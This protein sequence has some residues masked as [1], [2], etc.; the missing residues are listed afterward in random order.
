MLRTQGLDVA[1]VHAA[2]LRTDDVDQCAA[3]VL[4]PGVA[5][6]SLLAA[7]AE[8][9]RRGA[10]LV[11]FGGNGKAGL[12]RFLGTPADALLPVV[13]PP[14]PVPPPEPPAPPPPEKKPDPKQP[15]PALEEGEKEAYRVALLLVIDT[16][17][18]MGEK[19]KLQMAKQSAIAAAGA[20]SPQDRVGVIA[21][22]DDAR[23]VAA[24]QDATDLPTLN[25]KISALRLGNRTNFAAPLKMGYPRILAQPCGIR[26]VI[27]MTDGCETIPGVIEPMIRDGAAKGVTLST[28]GIGDDDD[29]DGNRL[30]K[31]VEWGKGKMYRARDPSRLPE[32]VTLDT[33]RFTVSKRDEAKKKDRPKTDA[34]DL[35]TPPADAPPVPADKPAPPEPPRET[36]APPRRPHVAS[37]ATCI[38]GLEK[39]EWPAL[40]FAETTPARPASQVVLAW[41]DATP[42]LTLG[43]AGLGRVA[44]ISAG[45]ASPEAGE[46]LRW[47]AAPQFLAQ[48]VRSVVDPPP[49]GAAPVAAEFV[50]TD[51]G[52][53]FVRVAAPGGGEL[54]LDP[55]RAGGPIAARCADRGTF[56]ITE[57]GAMPSAG[58]F[59]GTFSAPGAPPRRVVAVSAGPRPK[60]AGT[61]TRVATASGADVVDAAPPSHEGAPVEHQEPRELELVAAAAGLLLV[62]TALR[63]LARSA[64]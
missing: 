22:D 62:E 36:A 30:S 5:G 54:S 19:N 35:P 6:D 64:A 32:I 9:V 21:F 49:P 29:I 46:F 31:M 18:S 34:E 1:D 14:V 28:I 33:N 2:D 24:F 51:D 7:V 25:R 16:S 61:A 42:A 10:G 50:E 27:F 48:L 43:R 47:P 56:S 52:R 4:G 38:S 57:L 13:P 37:A 60:P 23:E 11:V 59:A 58:V 53:A 55:L 3:I 8:R 20:L 12:S 44:A 40:P 26:H 45:A 39:A 41:D 17:G 63:R 15:K